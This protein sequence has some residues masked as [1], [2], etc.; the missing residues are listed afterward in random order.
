MGLSSSRTRCS[1]FSALP[2]LGIERNLEGQCRSKGREL[3]VSIGS[4]VNGLAEGGCFHLYTRI[5]SSFRL[6]RRRKRGSS[7]EPGSR[8][9]HEAELPGF[10]Q[11]PSGPAH[12]SSKALR[13]LGAF[14]LH[15]RSILGT[16][17]LTDRALRCPRILTLNSVE[18]TGGLSVGHASSWKWMPKQDGGCNELFPSI[19]SATQKQNV[20]WLQFTSICKS[21]LRRER[22]AGS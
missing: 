21:T 8:T 7:A 4:R 12:R 16:T 6:V 20:D 3:W 18:G 5:S 15:E 17:F 1:G 9:S 19:P 22:K 14:L 13:M 11:K 2:N 10:Q